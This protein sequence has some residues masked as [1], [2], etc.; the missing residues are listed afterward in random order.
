MIGSPTKSAF[1][2]HGINMMSGQEIW[3]SMVIMSHVSCRKC[4]FRR[5]SLVLM[6]PIEPFERTILANDAIKLIS[7]S[8]SHALTWDVAS[9]FLFSR[10][11]WRYPKSLF[12]ASYHRLR[13][14]SRYQAPLKS[15][16]QGSY[17][18]AL[19]L[20]L[21]V[22]TQRS[23]SP[24]TLTRQVLLRAVGPRRRYELCWVPF[25][26]NLWRPEKSKSGGYIT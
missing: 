19:N 2:S 17:W 10:H 12:N 1:L 3:P 4:D 14:L 11:S 16:L 25:W 6:S 26:F 18:V 21:L 24:T 15:N 5:K 8:P 23:W 7:L 9:S 20:F 22:V 13:W